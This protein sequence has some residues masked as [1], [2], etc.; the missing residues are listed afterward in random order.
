MLRMLERAELM[1]DFL[2]FI[3]NKSLESDAEEEDDDRSDLPSCLSSEVENYLKEYR[4]QD[5]ADFHLTWSGDE[6]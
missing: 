3:T 2:L 5:T 1:P 4:P 6:N